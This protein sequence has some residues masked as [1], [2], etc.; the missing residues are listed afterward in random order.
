[1]KIEIWSDIACPWCYVGKRRFERA[2][3]SFSHRDDAD[4]TWRSFELDPTAPRQQSERQAEL[5]A[6]KYQVPLE[7]AEAMNANMTAAARKEGLDFHFDR[8]RVGNTFDA[9]RLIHFAATRGK[10]DAM[11]ERL[12]QAYLTEGQPLGDINVLVRLA[13]EVGLDTAAAREALESTTFGDS[14][15]ADEKRAQ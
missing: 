11:V 2:L 13:G 5:L 4:V 10:R 12:F 14:V 1:M 7:R 15:R 6:R 3:G 8:V 9:H